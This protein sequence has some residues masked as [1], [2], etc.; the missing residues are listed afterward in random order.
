MKR[1]RGAIRMSAALALLFA[2]L[3]LV[4]WRQSRTLEELRALE[5]ARSERAVLQAERSELQREL[6][7][8]ES[9][10]RIVAVAGER[11]KLRT[12]NADEIVFLQS[13]AYVA[14]AG[15][16]GER[17]PR[18]RLGAASGDANLAERR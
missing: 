11:L 14:H 1:G 13:P 4:I 8:L 10:A 5:A 3:A 18:T 7:R 17:W 2:S 16:T 15:G 12:P 6:Q 9:R